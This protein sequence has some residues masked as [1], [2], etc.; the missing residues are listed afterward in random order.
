MF[1]TDRVSALGN[2]VDAVHLSFRLSFEPT[3][4]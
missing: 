4:L 3:D 2:A 1:I